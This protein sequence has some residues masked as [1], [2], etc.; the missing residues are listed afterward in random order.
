MDNKKKKKYE[1]KDIFTDYIDTSSISKYYENVFEK[2]EITH[3]ITKSNSKLNMLVSRDKN[4]K[5]IYS[6]SNFII[7]ERN[8]ANKEANN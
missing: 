8:I 7:Y 4:Y 3:V 5:K 1:R 2:Y 6:D